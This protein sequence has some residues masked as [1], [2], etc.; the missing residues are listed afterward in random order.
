MYTQVVAT[1]VVRAASTTA[2]MVAFDNVYH[3]F[4]TTPFFSIQIQVRSVDDS[5]VRFY[6]LIDTTTHHHDQVPH[7]SVVA[8]L[9]W[10]DSDQQPTQ[11]AGFA[12]NA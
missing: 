7:R 10:H 4:G 8:N 2:T 1:A 11:V 3:C 6:T 5:D 12:I 9:A